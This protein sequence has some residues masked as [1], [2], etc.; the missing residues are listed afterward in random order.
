MSN[1]PSHTPWGAPQDWNEV[2]PG[3]WRTHTAGH[4]GFWLDRSRQAT[5]RR[6][7]PDFSTFA[8]GPWYEEDWAVPVLVF[9]GQF[10]D[11]DVHHAVEMVDLSLRWN[12]A[13]WK[14]VAEWLA[15]SPAGMLCRERANRY[16][17][18]V[19]N[20]W[21]SGS[22]GSTGPEYPRGVWRVSFTRGDERRSVIMP[23]PEKEYYT[24]EELA[25]L[26]YMEPVKA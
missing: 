17:E 19:A 24:T 7:L 4:G 13:R 9:A 10:D 8:G 23:Y 15:N 3:I 21:R 20:L 18:S 6:A 12:D 16:A 25:A 5:V 14:P 26:E 2:K 1:H 22:M 11:N